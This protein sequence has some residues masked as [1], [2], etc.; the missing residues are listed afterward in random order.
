M[1]QKIWLITGCSSGFGHAI[2]LAALAR[3]DTVVATARDPS[4]LSDLA[5]LGAL[6]EYLDV[7]DSDANLKA[8]IEKIVAKASTIDFLINNAGYILTGGIEECSR[9]EIQAQFDT[10]VFGQLNVIRAVLPVMRAARSGVVANVGS[11]GGW[12][13]PPAAGI[14]CSS[15]ACSTIVAEAL[16]AEVAHLGIKV[17]SIEP[18]YFRTNFL[19]AAH[20]KVAAKTIP[21]IHEAVKVTHDSLHKYN[22]AQPGDPNKAAALIVEALTGTGNCE[23][24]ELPPRLAIGKDAYTIINGCMDIHRGNMEN[25][26]HLTTATDFD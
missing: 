26:K 1:A 2:A 24:L 20:R 23:G 22:H 13:G 11:I 5:N 17:T 12:R 6:T 19:S 25:W 4:K 8:V 18:G 7:T 9:D 3:G 15:K 16:R 14:Y 21:E 10:N